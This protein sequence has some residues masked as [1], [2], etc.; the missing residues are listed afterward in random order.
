MVIYSNLEK[1]DMTTD[2]G[3]NTY[4]TAMIKKDEEKLCKE[5]GTVCAFSSMINAVAK[6][7]KLKS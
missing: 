5:I 4:I 1:K 3:I 6:S 7:D 2:L